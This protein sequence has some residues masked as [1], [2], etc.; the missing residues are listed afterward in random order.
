MYAQVPDAIDLSRA[1]IKKIQQ[2]L[3]WAFGYNIIAIPVAAGVLLPG[4]GFMLTPAISG[5]LMG[6][7]SLAVVTNS[8]LLQQQRTRKDKTVLL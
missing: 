7:S 5:A 8:L 4:Y 3:F 6:M 1:I 2:N